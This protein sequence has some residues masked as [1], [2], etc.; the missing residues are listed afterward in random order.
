[1]FI[2]LL[3][4]M[5]VIAFSPNQSLVRPTETA[6]L[7]EIHKQSQLKT[8]KPTFND[9]F[10]VWEKTIIHIISTCY[11]QPYKDITVYKMFHMP[12]I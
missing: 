5:S 8:Y 4:K 2:L 12:I 9:L 11:M 7:N 1:M 3:L 6:K 10:I